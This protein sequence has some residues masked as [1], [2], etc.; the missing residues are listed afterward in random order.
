M[1][2]REFT[3]PRKGI[4]KG[5]SSEETTSDYSEYMNNVRA[6]DVL[7]RK[8]RIGQRPAVDKW[9]TDQ[10]GAAENPVVAI[11]SVSAVV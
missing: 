6:I 1:A 5:L 10:I 2:Y 4:F 8:V 7:E 11:C 3:L 9:S